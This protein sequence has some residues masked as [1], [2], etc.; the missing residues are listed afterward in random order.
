[1]RSRFGFHDRDYLRLDWLP[2]DFDVLFRNVNV[3]FRSNAKLSFEVNSGLDRKADSRNHPPR[4]A[5]LEIVDVDAVAVSFFANRMT[6]AMREL[7]AET[8]ACDYATGHII[9]FGATNRFSSADILAHKIDRRITGFPH[10][11]ENA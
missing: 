7:F 9:D 4:I 11:V 8:C 1:M 6:G 5:C 2:G 10:N 3:D